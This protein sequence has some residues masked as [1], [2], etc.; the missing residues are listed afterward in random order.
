MGYYVSSNIHHKKTI[1]INRMYRRR[2]IYYDGLRIC[3]RKRGNRE[4]NRIGPLA[5]A[6]CKM[7]N[8][9]ERSHKLNRRIGRCP[10]L[11]LNT[12]GRW[13]DLLDLVCNDSVGVAY[14]IEARI[15]NTS[16]KPHFRQ[17]SFQW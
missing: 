6:K 9:L 7:S 4:G 2:K 8:W 3:K 1:D 13:V 10:S 16:P 14:L 11:G 12:L 15:P 5:L 17:V